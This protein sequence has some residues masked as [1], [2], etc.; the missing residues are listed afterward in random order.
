M[1]I[2]SYTSVAAAN[3]ALFPENML[4]SAVNDNMRQVQ[5]D[6]K[7]WYSD[8][9]WQRQEEAPSRASAT[10]FKITGD[11]TTKYL[12]NRAIRV[13][14]AATYVGIIT[15]SSYSAPDTTITVNLDSGS[16]TASFTAVAI[17]VLS[18]TNRSIPTALG[19]KGADVASASTINLSTSSGDFCDV[20][21]TTTITAITTEAAGIVR[22]VRFTGILTLTHNAT[23]LILPGAAN[24]TTANGDTAIFRSL[25]SGNWVCISYEK[26]SGNYVSMRK[27]ADIASATTTDLSTATGDFVDV[28]GTTTITGLGTVDA[29]VERTVRFTGA[30]T[31]THNSTSLKLPG[32]ANITTAA[33]DTA[34]FRSLGSGNWQCISYTKASGAAIVATT[35]AFSTSFTSSQQT[36]TAAGSLTLAHGLGAIPSLIQC[37]LVCQSADLNYSTND[38]LLIGTGESSDGANYGL[39]IVPDSTNINVRFASTAGTFWAVNKTTGVRASIANANWKLVVKAWA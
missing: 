24:I 21:G 14:D 30:L 23:T 39:S 4:P 12:V 19:R 11:V 25:G 35:S 10:T 28:T 1:G 3:T 13:N 17:G 20:T 32:A 38:V 18:P 27:G 29:G 16:L 22:A 5:A 15:A 26:V 9:E 7:A 36:I 37:Q 6:L 33:N 2:Q 34:I 8:S 31:L